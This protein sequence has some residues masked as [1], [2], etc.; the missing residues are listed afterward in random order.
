MS[1]AD[2]QRQDGIFA[3]LTA[4]S[5]TL[6]LVSNLVASKPI[7]LPFGMVIPT[8]AF[9]FPFIF[10][11]GGIVI[12]NYGPKALKAN[13]AIGFVCNALA[14]ALYMFTLV[15]PSAEY[16][17]DQ[18]AMQ[19][20]MMITPRMLAASLIAYAF[21]TYLSSRV[22]DLLRIALGERL[23]WIRSLASRVVGTMLDASSF[24]TLAFAGIFAGPDLAVMIWST[25]AVRIVIDIIITP[26]S[27]VIAT[28]VKNS[29]ASRGIL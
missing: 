1:R 22:L 3:V 23:Y 27:S 18:T 2:S 24:L 9:F 14:V 29:I 7:S 13:I 28:R 20:V 26:L 4:I 8:S 25:I 16:W 6:V 12:E 21:S 5:T 15:L 11:I 17:G 19:T 10:L